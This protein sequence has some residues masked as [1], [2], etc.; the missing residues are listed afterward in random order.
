MIP[1]LLGELGTLVSSVKR[2]TFLLLGVLGVV[3]GEP[4]PGVRP[5]GLL[6]PFFMLRLPVVGA[7][8]LG[9]FV[10]EL[11]LLSKGAFDDR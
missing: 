5:G 4:L 1:R 9:V 8:G 11:E 10:L 6:G 7:S 3:P 2:I